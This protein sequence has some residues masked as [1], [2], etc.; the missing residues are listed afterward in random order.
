MSL[1]DRF[2]LFNKF[3]KKDGLIFEEIEGQVS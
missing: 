1:D 2:D 3:S